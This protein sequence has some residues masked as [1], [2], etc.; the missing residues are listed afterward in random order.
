VRAQLV[1]AALI[2]LSLGI[3]IEELHRAKAAGTPGLTFPIELDTW[4]D[5]WKH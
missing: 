4:D 5:E 3:H 1:R 2:Y